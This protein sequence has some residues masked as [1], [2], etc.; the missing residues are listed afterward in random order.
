M[1]AI[2]QNEKETISK[3]EAARG[4]KS[5]RCARDATGGNKKQG[6]HLNSEG[7]D[8]FFQ[9]ANLCVQRPYNI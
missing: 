9:F 8:F 7:A 4:E 2:K 6:L 5:K 3:M 1:F